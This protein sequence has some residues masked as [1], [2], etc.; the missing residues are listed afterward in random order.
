MMKPSEEFPYILFTKD[1][2]NGKRFGSRFAIMDWLFKTLSHEN[3]MRYLD[4]MSKHYM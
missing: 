2:P 4:Y 1:F 3:K